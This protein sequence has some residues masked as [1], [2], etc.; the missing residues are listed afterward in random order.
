MLKSESAFLV[1]QYSTWIF[2]FGKIKKDF[3]VENKT[4]GYRFI[5]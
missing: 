4:G 2:K 5:E 1:C 3:I